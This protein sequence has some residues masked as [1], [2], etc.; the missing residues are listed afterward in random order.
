MRLIVKVCEFQIYII[1]VIL[2]NIICFNFFFQNQQLRLI[3]FQRQ[4]LIKF[5]NAFR[6]HFITA[7]HLVHVTE[8]PIYFWNENISQLLSGLKVWEN[9]KSSFQF[10]KILFKLKVI[11]HVLAMT[12]NI[13]YIVFKNCYFLSVFFYYLN[14]FIEGFLR[15]TWYLI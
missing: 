12:L 8:K 3:R 10:L 9:I 7:H 4:I 2:L 11:V 14:L 6:H 15:F 5:P 1:F 13:F